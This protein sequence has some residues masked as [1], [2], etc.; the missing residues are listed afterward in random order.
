M[1]KLALSQLKP[2]MKLAKD[3]YLHDGRLLLLAGFAIKSIYIRK[4]EAFNVNEIYVEEGQYTPVE[5]YDEEK[6]YNHAAETVKNIFTMARKD[7]YADISIVRDTVSDILHKV[8][9]NEIIML[10][11][12]GI[13]DIDNYTFLHS[14][15]VCIYSIIIGKRLGY[16]N[17]PLMALGMGAILHDIGKCKVPFE[18]LL[19]PGRLTDDEFDLMKLHTVYGYEI[20]KNSYRL[21][22]KIANIAFQHHEKWNGS[23][24]PMRTSSS[25]I[26]PLARIVA[27]SDV[28]DALTSDRVYKKRTLPHIAAEYIKNNAGTLFDPFIV[29]LFTSSIAVYNEGTLVLLSTGEL[30]SIVS[31]GKVGDARQKVSVFSNKSGPPV[32]KPYIVDLNERKDVEIVEIFL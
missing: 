17:D 32:L 30:G 15:D 4:L 6:I 23:G 26:D 31:S 9:E 27:L 29:D 14:I 13:R 22:T 25:A 10:Q 19:K 24:Y 7:E 1:I 12:T 2:G 11:L 18:I 28:Y 16:G 8:I 5:E 20:I 3:I 21:S